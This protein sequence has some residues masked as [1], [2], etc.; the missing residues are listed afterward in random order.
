[1]NQVTQFFLQHMSF[2]LLGSP[3]TAKS[4]AKAAAAPAASG[5]SAPTAKSDGGP[6]LRGEWGNLALLCLLYLGQ[7]H[8]GLV[9]STLFMKK[10]RTTIHLILF[11]A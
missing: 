8:G 6:D 4:V 3:A 11:M 7:I 5:V 10:N 9:G 1:M 2:C